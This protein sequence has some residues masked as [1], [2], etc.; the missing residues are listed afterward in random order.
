MPTWATLLD[1]YNP[2]SEYLQK[3]PE[4]WS[5][6]FE[7]RLLQNLYLNFHQNLK[8]IVALSLVISTTLLMPVIVA[9]LGSMLYSRLFKSFVRHVH[10]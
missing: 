9:A 10:Y 8:A 7:S 6:L 1:G 5:M 4:V 3:M 2:F